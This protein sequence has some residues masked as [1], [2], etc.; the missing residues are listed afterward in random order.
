[1][2]KKR[3]DATHALD[4]AASLIRKCGQGNL[5]KGIKEVMR[6]TGADES[7]VRRWMYPVEKDG[8]GGR[9][10]TAHQQPL[11]DWGQ[12]L[13]LIEPR[14]FFSRPAVAGQIAEASA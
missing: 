10:P 7:R 4:P 6:V 9:I 1:M 3:S 2:S 13:G 14:D 5:R 11:L 8:T 12:P